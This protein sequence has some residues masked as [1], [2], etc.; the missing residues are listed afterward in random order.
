SFHGTSNKRWGIT[1]FEIIE[2]R[3]P[4]RSEESDH[5]KVRE[6]A[7]YVL[8]DLGYPLP[9]EEMADRRVAVILGF[10]ASRKD[11]DRWD[12]LWMGNIEMEFGHRG[13]TLFWLGEADAGESVPYLR[14]LLRPTL[15]E[16]SRERLVEAMGVHSAPAVVVPAMEAVIRND[17]SAE[18]REEAASW[19]GHQRSE[20]ALDVLVWTVK[21]D[22]DEEVREEAVNAIERFRN[23]RATRTLIE[24]ARQDVHREV[25]EEAVEALGRRRSGEALEALKNIA[26]EDSHRDVQEEAVEAM[27]PF[28][29][30][31]RN[32]TLAVIASQHP[33]SAVREEA[34]EVL[35][36]ST[37]AETAVIL[38]GVVRNDASQDV[39][40]EALEALLALPDEKGVEALASIARSH[41]RS[42]IRSEA[43]ELLE[44]SQGPAARDAVKKLRQ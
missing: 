13:R 11:A 33:S 28:P 6:A 29:E 38:A 44:S 17:P 15:S 35:R 18:V 24:V 21:N 16:G 41:P 5:D 9:E 19:L 34:V 1:L 39:Q 26:F 10:D 37:S 14:S 8:E 30:S 43:I 40:E 22:P 31:E 3:A 7:R 42:S 20:A 27:L 32:A 36:M 23:D 2:G 25:R 4:D 12:L